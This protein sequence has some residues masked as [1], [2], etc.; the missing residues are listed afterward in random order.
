LY[1]DTLGTNIGKPHVKGGFLAGHPSIAAD[2]LD[3]MAIDPLTQ[4]NRDGHALVTDLLTEMSGLSTSAY[5]HI[6]GDE[7]NPG[8]WNATET[9]RSYVLHKFGAVDKFAY[10]KL[11]AEWHREVPTPV[12]ISV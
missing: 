5:F 10:R 2:R 6:G 11:A 12:N 1:Q 8:C 3:A 4:N 7:V 9:I